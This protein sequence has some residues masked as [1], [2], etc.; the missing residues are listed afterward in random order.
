[1]E[2]RLIQ[3]LKTFLPILEI[4]GERITFFND[5]QP[6]KTWSSIR[7]VPLGITISSKESQEAK[8]L[9]PR[10]IKELGRLTL[11]SL[12]QELKTPL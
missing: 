4:V 9:S 3:S 11:L 7:V 2:T 5:E 12:R 1:M 10:A 8:A 6:E